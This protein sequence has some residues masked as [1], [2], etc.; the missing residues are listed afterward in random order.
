MVI[1]VKLPPHSHKTPGDVFG[2]EDESIDL[3]ALAVDDK[4]GGLT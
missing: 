2:L 1:I 3:L 4:D